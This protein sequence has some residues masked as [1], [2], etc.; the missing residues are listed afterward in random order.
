MTTLGKLLAL[1]AQ[2]SSSRA[3]SKSSRREVQTGLDCLARLWRYAPVLLG[4]SDAAEDLVEATCLRA[5]ECAGQFFPGARWTAG[6]SR[7]Y[8]RSGSTKFARGGSAKA[9]RSS[10]RRARSGS[11]ANRQA[12][13]TNI[14]AAL[15]LKRSDRCRRPSA[16]RSCWSTAKVIARLKPQARWE[17]LSLP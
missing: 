10:T 2:S 1:E 13:E 16:K 11:R 9:A 7:P 14:L 12:V 15:S 8:G 3:T 4:T 17:S 5:V 6:C